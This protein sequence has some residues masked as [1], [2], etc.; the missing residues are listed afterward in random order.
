MIGGVTIIFIL[1]FGGVTF[2]DLRC[3]NYISI[4]NFDESVLTY[5]CIAPVPAATLR[6]AL[7][8]NPQA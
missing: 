1:V 3:D 4:N 2:S 7:P 8:P 6:V 5:V